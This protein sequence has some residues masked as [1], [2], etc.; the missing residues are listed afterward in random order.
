MS[1]KKENILKSAI[2]L[3][4]ELGY[5]S[6]STNKVAKAAGVS[7]GLIFRHFT[8]KEGLL[9]AILEQVKEKT[10]HIYAPILAKSDPEDLIRAV[11][12]MPFELDK[13]NYHE[14]RLVY[15]LKWQSDTYD[16][17][18][19][20]PIRLELVK[21]FTKLKYENPKAEAETLLILLDGIATAVL[22]KK[23]ENME[24]IKQSILKKYNI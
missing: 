20:D 3:F 8:N 10:F 6:T 1:A 23:T 7:E 21:A 12:S 4:S 16:S 13:S 2:R 9:K 19:S 22:L 24:N 18:M 14:W 15:S 17:S 5:A 11:L